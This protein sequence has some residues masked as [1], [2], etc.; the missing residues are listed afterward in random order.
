MDTTL[1]LLIIGIFAGFFIQTVIGFGGALIALPF[2]LIV[3]PLSEAVSY[4]SIFYLISS[5]IYVY[6]EWDQIDKNLLKKIAFSSFFGVLAGILV[7]VYGK[8]L[9]LKQALGVFIILFVLNSFRVKK[10]VV[11]L[12]KTKHILGFL[13]GFFSGLFSTGG[14][15]Y[16][17]ILQNETTDVKTFR[18]TM[19]GTLALVT[20]MRIPVLIAGG[21]MSMTQVYNSF[22]VLPFFILALFLGKKVYLKLNEALIKRVVIA[23]LFVSGVMLVFKV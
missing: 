7:L 19:F 14:P 21:V 15:L 1:L 20:L 4:I 23:L 18:A 10:N 16:V 13:G 5:P 2:L 6:K 9:I 17:I 12:K 3:M 22:Y 11:I 8:P